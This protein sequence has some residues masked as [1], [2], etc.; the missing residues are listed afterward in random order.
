MHSN[1]FRFNVLIGNAKSLELIVANVTDLRQLVSKHDIY[2]KSCSANIS[3]T[4]QNKILSAETL[5]FLKQL[6]LFK[7]YNSVI[8]MLMTL[9]RVNA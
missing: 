8:S 1:L 3:M 7:P 2:N 6:L 5:D 9:R 4:S